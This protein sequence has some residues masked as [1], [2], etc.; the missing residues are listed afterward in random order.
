MIFTEEKVFVAIGGDIMVKTNNLNS[1]K[2]CG[3]PTEYQSGS[4]EDYFCSDDCI[5]YAWIE[6][7]AKGD[8]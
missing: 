6:Y 1:C 8:I 5:E 7:D 4:F 2:I 3:R